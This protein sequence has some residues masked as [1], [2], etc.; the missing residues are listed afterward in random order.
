MKTKELKA[1]AKVYP[2]L[3]EATRKLCAARL[4]TQVDKAGKAHKLPSMSKTPAKHTQ[5]LPGPPE[6]TSPSPSIEKGPAEQ[7]GALAALPADAKENSGGEQRKQHER[8][9]ENALLKA[10]VEYLREQQDSKVQ[11]K[12]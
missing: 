5:T 7:P 9:R 8:R 11:L 4:M 2:P 6:L 10:V 12:S 3:S 1:A